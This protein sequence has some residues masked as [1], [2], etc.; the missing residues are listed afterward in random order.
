MHSY[1]QPDYYELYLCAESL[2][3]KHIYV[4]YIYRIAW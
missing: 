1:V 2:S 4:D 3:I